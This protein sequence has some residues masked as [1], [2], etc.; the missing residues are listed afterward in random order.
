MISTETETITPGT[1]KIIVNVFFVSDNDPI[2]S[3]EVSV[4]NV[5]C[6]KVDAGKYQATLSSL[7][8]YQS[9]DVKVDVP[10]FSRLEVSNSVIPLGNVVMWVILVAILIALLLFAYKLRVNENRL[11]KLK[12][13]VNQKGKVTVEEIGK[14]LNLDVDSAEKLLH[15]LAKQ[16]DVDGSFTSDGKEFITSERL[17]KELMRNNDEKD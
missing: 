1:V 3:G 14:N 10:N 6:T 2:E 13:L 5:K 7:M 15:E 9:F 17:E 4:N 11:S 16:D 8:P 12:K